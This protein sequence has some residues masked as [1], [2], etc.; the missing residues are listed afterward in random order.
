MSEQKSWKDWQLVLQFMN[1]LIIFKLNYCLF[2][3]LMLETIS[4]ASSLMLVFS[5]WYKSKRN[6]A[7]TGNFVG[8]VEFTSK[9]VCWPRI[10]NSA[11][12]SEQDFYF[13]KHLRAQVD[14][15][16]HGSFSQACSYAMAF[17]FVTGVESPFQAKPHQG[18]YL[19]WENLFQSNCII[20]VHQTTLRSFN[21]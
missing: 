16:I 9:P 19:A 7:S 17:L 20:K 11:I 18:S 15:I 8:G 1:C 6:S 3:F 14:A 5:I 21:L 13:Y 4:E 10:C 12:I 2:P